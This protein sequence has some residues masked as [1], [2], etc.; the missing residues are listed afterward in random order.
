MVKELW[1]LVQFAEVGNQNPN[2]ESAQFW[3]NFGIQNPNP[4]SVFYS[5][6]GFLIGSLKLAS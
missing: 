6:F 2:P 5:V 4:E 3:A 1:V